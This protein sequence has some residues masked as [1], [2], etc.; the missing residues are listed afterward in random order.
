MNEY[1][2]TIYYTTKVTVPIWANSPDEAQKKAEEM[3]ADISD[4]DLLMRLE[5]ADGDN[6]YVDQIK[7]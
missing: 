2:V 7:K 1:N 5:I 4:T 6:Y 3:E